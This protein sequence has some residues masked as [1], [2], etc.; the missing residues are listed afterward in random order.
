MQGKL[1]IDPDL[2][3]SAPVR[4]H[5]SGLKHA[6]LEPGSL[7]SSPSPAFLLLEALEF[8]QTINRIV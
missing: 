1:F 5:R 8:M 6:Q 7:S 2:S 4:T 3:H